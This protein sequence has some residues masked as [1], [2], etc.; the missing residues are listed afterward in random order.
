MIRQQK[1]VISLIFPKKLKT[2]QLAK[3]FYKNSK[4]LYLREPLKNQFQR[5]T[6][7]ILL[8]IAEGSAK[9]TA[10]DRKRFYAISLGSLRETQ[11]ILDLID[12]KNPIEEADVLGRPLCF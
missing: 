7:S 8:N 10:K 5:A 2:Y 1:S 9:P 4:N 11:A 6:L 3:E 12:H